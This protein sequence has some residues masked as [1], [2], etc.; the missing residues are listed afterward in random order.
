MSAPSAADRFAGLL[1]GQAVGDGLGLPY[2]NLP[3]ARV[4]RRLG[5]RELRPALLAGWTAGSDDTAHAWAVGQALLES[6]GDPDRFRAA[7]GR[8]LRAWF[9]TL[10]A[11]IGLATLRAMVRLCVG[12]P[13]DRSGVA[14]T[15]HSRTLLVASPLQQ[16]EL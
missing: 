7:L 9:L 10:P 2:E 6:G 8:R 16:D 14:L 15:R 13:P 11:G 1:L 3:P 12:V 5:D 4:A